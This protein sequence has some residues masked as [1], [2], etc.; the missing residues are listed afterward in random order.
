MEIREN[1]YFF[2]EKEKKYIYIWEIY[3]WSI[4]NKLNYFISYLDEK[5]FEKV[6]D[7]SE[8]PPENNNSNNESNENSDVYKWFQII[9]MMRR[10]T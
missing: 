6:S 2:W 5:P 7:N 9:I 4:Y 8:T 10:G 3:T 1:I